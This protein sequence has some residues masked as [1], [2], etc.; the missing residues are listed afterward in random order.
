[1]SLKRVSVQAPIA[2]ARKGRTGDCHEDR[3]PIKAE[4]APPGVIMSAKKISWKANF[5]LVLFSFL[6]VFLLG[7]VGLR[8]I[9]YRPPEILTPDIRKT[10][11]LNPNGE[12]IY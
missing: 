1:M 5:G 11:N 9:G 6:F 12:F 3:R 2:R 4:I 8:I 10:Y 7:E